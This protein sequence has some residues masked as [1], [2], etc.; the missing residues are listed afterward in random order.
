M[1]LTVS[2]HFNQLALAD[3]N[4][5]GYTD[6]FYLNDQFAIIYTADNPDDPSQGVTETANWAS[7]RRGAAS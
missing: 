1:N 7:D 2:P 4:G 5:D 6:I 3:F